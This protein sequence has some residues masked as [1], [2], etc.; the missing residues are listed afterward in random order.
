M[1]RDA[2]YLLFCGTPTPGSENLGLQTLTPALKT[3]TP[4]PGLK[5][6]SDSRTAYCVAY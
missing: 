1:N 4:T 5:S 3:W 6:D 2:E